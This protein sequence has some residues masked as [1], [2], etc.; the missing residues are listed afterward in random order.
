MGDFP[1]LTLSEVKEEV[2]LMGV[3]M[4][5]TETTQVMEVTTR[6]ALME[7]L[8]TLITTLQTSTT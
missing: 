2:H 6:M 8:V 3:D 7:V 5:F 1:E 4:A